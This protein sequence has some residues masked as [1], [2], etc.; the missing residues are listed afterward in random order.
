[1][2]SDRLSGDARR[3]SG[4][5]HNMSLCGAPQVCSQSGIGKCHGHLFFLGRSSAARE[6]TLYASAG[7]ASRIFVNPSL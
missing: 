2:T 6:S 4:L 1:M 5:Y 7:W 3:W